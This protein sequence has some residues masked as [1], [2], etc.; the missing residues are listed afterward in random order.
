MRPRLPIAA[1]AA[2]IA[3]VL[4]ATAQA[5]NQ[6]LSVA[7]AGS[8]TGTV[9]SSPAGIECGPTCSLSFAQGALVTLSGTPGPNTQAVT[10]SGC[11]GVNAE[12]KCVVEMLSAKAVTATFK[13]IAHQLT[14]EKKG[15]G[16][17]TVTSSPAGIECG[18]TC[19]FAF[20]HGATV[21]LSGAPGAGSQPVQW[22]GCDSVNGE[23]KCIVAI[24]A[25]K[26]V[27]ATFN[28]AS[29]QLSVTKAG[30][31][32]GTVTSSPAGIECGPTCSAP[33]TH[34]AT[35]TLSGSPGPN[36]DPVVQWSGCDSVNAEGKCEV[37]IGAARAV[38]ATFALAKHQLTVAKNGTGTGTVSSSPAGIECGPTCS[39]PF[40]HGA[41]VTLTGSPG[42]HS[43]AVKWSGC[44]SVNGEDKCIVAISAARSV[45]ANFALESQYLEYTLAVEKT[46][47][48]QG[49]VSSSPGQI[50]CG[51]LCAGQFLTGTTLTLTATPSPGSVFAHWSGGG[52][53][54]AGPCETTVKASKTVKAVFTAVGTRTLSVTKAGSGQGT[55]NA[56]AAGIECG[57]A[58]SAQV[59]AAKKVTLTAVPASGSSFAR[60]SG[61]CS[62]TAKT[63]TVTMSE[64]RSL[65]AAFTANASP[66]A[67]PSSGCVVPKL[68]G[69]SLAKAKAKLAAAHCS[70]GKVLRPKRGRGLVVRSSSPAAGSTLAAG[71]K[72]GVRLARRRGDR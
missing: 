70:L 23:N 47:T 36:T 28:L 53:S 67:P 71:A 13:P 38:T 25:A 63:C 26:A 14:V 24:G 64:A 55:V 15:P 56:K 57:Q 43:Q 66:P 29:H 69:K 18:P 30:P 44:D 11:D 34:G 62:G 65:T 45:T 2:T 51:A 58:C 54:G 40:T 68:A 8:G 10:W 27:S 61:A 46:G 33:Y 17:G 7:K 3:L 59:P 35:V 31:G 9:S 39:A 19:S 48:G 72:V 20:D 60:W 52:C 1:L 16:T 41:T 49:T 5:A 42:G 4:P 32:T 50:N 22:S 6:T 37:T 12:N 21:T